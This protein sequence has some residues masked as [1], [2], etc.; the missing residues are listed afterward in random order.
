[1]ACFHW[2]RQSKSWLIEVGSQPLPP[3]VAAALDGDDAALVELYRDLRP[4]IERLATFNCGDP[5][6]AADLAQA[7]LPEVLATLPGYERSSPSAIAF[8]F[9]VALPLMRKQDRASLPSAEYQ[10]PSHYLDES[11]ATDLTATDDPVLT[12]M[13]QLPPIWQE[14][15][16]LRLL[17]GLTLREVA[18]VLR[19]KEGPLCH[20]QMRALAVLAEWIEQLAKSDDQR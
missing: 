10:L 16:Q 3:L 6:R 12:A 1:M 14:L 17:A 15:L 20:L 9:A 7:V 8:C 13:Q 5:G 19:R 11:G 4:R 2:E 18:F